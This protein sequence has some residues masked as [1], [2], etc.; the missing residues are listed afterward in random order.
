M[1][2]TVWGLGTDILLPLLSVTND[3]LSDRRRRGWGGS[4]ADWP[5]VGHPSQSLAK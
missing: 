3:S 4:V 2:G 1:A 5:R